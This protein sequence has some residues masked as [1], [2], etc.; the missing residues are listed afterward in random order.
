M[1]K[2]SCKIR[3]TVP[4]TKKEVIKW[5]GNSVMVFVCSDYVFVNIKIK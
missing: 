3:N 5:F 2:S 1:R 4:R